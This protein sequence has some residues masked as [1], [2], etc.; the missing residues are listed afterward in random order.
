MVYM[1]LIGKSN[2]LYISF[3]HNSFLFYSKYVKKKNPKEIIINYSFSKVN[4]IVT[5][6][7]VHRNL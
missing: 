3:T 2:V 4:V 6:G 1:N 7:T 5:N